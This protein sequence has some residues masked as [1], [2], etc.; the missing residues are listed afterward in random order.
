MPEVQETVPAG[1][2]P[3]V[4]VR[5]LPPESGKSVSSDVHDGIDV[6][7]EILTGDALEKSPPC[8]VGSLYLWEF[9]KLRAFRRGE[10]PGRICGAPAKYRMRLRCH[11]CGADYRLFMCRTDAFKFRHG[12][13]T[14]CRF[15]GQKKPYAKAS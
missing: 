14:C 10:Y 13:Q 1:K 5:G 6:D 8:E 7:W 11:R 9:S 2:Q 4:P 12:W 3:A 15:C